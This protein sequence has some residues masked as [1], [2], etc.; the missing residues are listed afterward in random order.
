MIDASPQRNLR[1][2]LCL[3]FRVS[4]ALGA[5]RLGRPEGQNS[6]PRADSPPSMV[7]MVPVM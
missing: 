4:V 5:S 7:I 6:R 1:A 2:F 3:S